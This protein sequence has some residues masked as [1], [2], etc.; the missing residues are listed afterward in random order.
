[1]KQ[2]RSRVARSLAVGAALAAV[3]VPTA[4]AMREPLSPIDAGSAIPNPVYTHQYSQPDG[5][6][7][8]YRP[9]DRAG[10]RGVR[11][12]HVGDELVTPSG[13]RSPALSSK[14]DLGIG[15]ATGVNADDRAGVRGPGLVSE[16]TPVAAVGGDGFNWGDAGL[17]AATSLAVVLSLIGM[18]AVLR[19]SRRS[20][21]AA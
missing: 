3:A 14:E 9:G 10:I 13:R 12:A 16:P 20:Q 7:Q 2:Y 19:R 15:V 11:L 6:Q 4:Q 8:Y 5:T 18:T 21:L 1:M 17:G